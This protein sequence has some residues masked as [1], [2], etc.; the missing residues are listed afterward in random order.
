MKMKKDFYF[1]TYIV[2]AIII[3]LMILH[4][5]FI[6]KTNYAP[7]NVL[8]QVKS[9]KGIPEKGAECYA[10]ITSFQINT[11]NKPLEKLESLY[12]FIAA[13][14]FSVSEEKGFHLL[15]TG[16][17]EYNEKFDIKIICYSEELRGVS[18]TIINNTNM[19]CEIKNNGKL[20][21]C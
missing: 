12:D 10:D 1:K 2:I 6:I 11:Q 21:L 17:A 20:L 7:E 5:E 14:T 3:F 4:I 15:E 13:R 9:D 8:I 16:F 18:Y 19:N